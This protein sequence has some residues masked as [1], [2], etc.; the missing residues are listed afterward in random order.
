MLPL[1]YNWIHKQLL[2]AAVKRHVFALIGQSGIQW[3]SLII[4]PQRMY[5]S[6]IAYLTK[7]DVYV[8][9]FNPKLAN[10]LYLW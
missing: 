1:F 3:L 2:S 8:Q 4:S 5:Q 9:V 10:G 7:A 6:Q